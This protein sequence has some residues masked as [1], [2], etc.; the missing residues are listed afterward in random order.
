M[1]VI[2]NYVISYLQAQI[3]QGLV[4]LNNELESKK[5]NDLKIQDSKLLSKV[6]RRNINTDLFDTVLEF[7]DLKWIMIMINILLL[8]LITILIWLLL[9]SPLSNTPGP[10]M[11][12]FDCLGTRFFHIF[13][14]TS[15]PINTQLKLLFQKFPDM[16]FVLFFKNNFMEDSSKIG[17]NC[18]LVKQIQ[19]VPVFFTNCSCFFSM[20]VGINVANMNS[21]FSII[22]VFGTDNPKLS[23]KL[24][25]PVFPHLGVRLQSH[26][27]LYKLFN[28]IIKISFQDNII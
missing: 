20:N 15:L 11:N 18:G 25:G 22:I 19:Y 23:I 21:Y 12:I 7:R 8:W 1:L 4:T 17:S 26:S 6:C 3:D 13:L 14:C 2:L 27:R 5:I 9:T 10:F 24:L 16:K 28:S